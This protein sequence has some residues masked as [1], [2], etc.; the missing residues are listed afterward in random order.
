M[1]LLKVLFKSE[2]L[3]QDMVTIKLD[4]KLSNSAMYEHRCLQK[5][6][7]Y[8]NCWKIWW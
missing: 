6:K 1:L 8:K 5:I 2:L 3:K 4:Q 7:T